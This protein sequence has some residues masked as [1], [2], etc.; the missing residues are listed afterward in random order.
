MGISSLLSKVWDVI[1]YIFT[2]AKYFNDLIRD[3]YRF[4]QQEL[5]C[6]RFVEIF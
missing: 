2:L 4:R 5:F 3:Y 1:E 6:E